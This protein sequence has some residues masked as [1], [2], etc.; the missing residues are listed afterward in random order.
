MIPEDMSLYYWRVVPTHS[1]IYGITNYS[2]A[3]FATSLLEAKHLLIRGAD[4]RNICI[5]GHIKD[6]EVVFDDPD[7]IAPI[8][9]EPEVVL[10]KVGR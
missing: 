9:E 10:L 5:S 3:V 2:F 4:E 6:G 8:K 1:T 7:I